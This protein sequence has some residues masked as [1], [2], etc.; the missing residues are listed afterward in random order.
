MDKKLNKFWRANTLARANAHVFC[1]A[2]DERLKRADAISCSVGQ[3]AV[4][5]RGSGHQLVVLHPVHVLLDD[6]FQF[7]L[8]LALFLH[9]SFQVVPHQQVVQ[10][11]D[12]T[13]LLTVELQHI[14]ILTILIYAVEV[15]HG[16]GFCGGSGRS[17]IDS[18][19]WAGCLSAAQ[20]RRACPLAP[21]RWDQ[22]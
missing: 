16:V 6:G 10:G 3:P 5:L 13:R 7:L 11:I 17:P 21:L 15:V 12:A 19:R 4:R 14:V 8:H 22:R 9:P 18:V 20:C 2:R 1:E